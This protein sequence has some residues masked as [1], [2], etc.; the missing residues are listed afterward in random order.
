MLFRS[1][2]NAKAHEEA[3]KRI[4]LS[5]LERKLAVDGMS[6]AEQSV[7][8]NLMIKWGLAGTMTKETLDGMEQA[9]KESTVNG[10]LDVNLLIAAIGRLMQFDG[11]TVDLSVLT[12]YYDYKKSGSTAPPGPKGGGGSPPGPPPGPGY[13]WDGHKWIPPKKGAA[14]LDFVVPPGYPNDSYPVWVQNYERVKVETPAQ[15]ASGKGGGDVNI[16]MPVT[17]VGGEMDWEQMAWR[18]ARYMQRQ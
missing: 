12:T 3:T 15:Q 1:D 17:V 18:L 13:T 11:K 7:L 4:A 14:G 9:I 2:A 5:M 8:D 16:S 10:I 6:S